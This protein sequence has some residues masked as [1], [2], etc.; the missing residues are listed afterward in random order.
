MYYIKIR[1]WAR[2]SCLLHRTLG[3]SWGCIRSRSQSHRSWRSHKKTSSYL[4]ALQYFAMSSHCTWSFASIVGKK[5]FATAAYS[6]LA[7]RARHSCAGSRNYCMGVGGSVA[8]PMPLAWGARTK[9]RLQK[10]VQTH[11]NYFFYNMSIYARGRGVISYIGIFS[12]WG[13]KAM[14]KNLLR[15]FLL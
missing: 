10:H 8:R 9:I 11:P 14:S 4:I 2:E 7:A 6:S 15:W 13:V 1:G 3:G 12:R 5:T